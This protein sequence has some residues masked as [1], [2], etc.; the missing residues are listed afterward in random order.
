[1]VKDQL[2]KKLPTGPTDN[3][4]YFEIVNGEVAH[5]EVIIA[6]NDRQTPE[7]K[8]SQQEEIHTSVSDDNDEDDDNSSRYEWKTAITRKMLSKLEEKK[9][10]SDKDFILT[11]KL[12]ADVAKCMAKDI[13]GS[14][15]SAT[16]C[17]DKLYSLKRG[18]RKF[19]SECKRPKTFLF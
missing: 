14:A 11:K 10:A 19:L 16:Q 18:N 15:A 3:S 5:P 6:G 2:S 7:P 12:W 8:N 13:S 9:T 4:I 17:R 1:M